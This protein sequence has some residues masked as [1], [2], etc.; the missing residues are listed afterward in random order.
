[1][2]GVNRTRK[3]RPNRGGAACAALRA[4]VFGWSAL[5]FV[6]GLGS[7]SPAIAAARA[8]VD[9][10]TKPLRHYGSLFGV[11]LDTAGIP[12]IAAR[13]NIIHVESSVSL[14]IQTEGGRFA[15][16]HLPAGIYQVLGR[17]VGYTP[18]LVDSILVA[19]EERKHV[20]VVLLR[21]PVIL[22]GVKVVER[23]VPTLSELPEGF[24]SAEDSRNILGAAELRA[25]RQSATLFDAMRDLRPLLLGGERASAYRHRPELYIDGKYVPCLAATRMARTGDDCME[26]LLGELLVE[27]VEDVQYLDASKAYIVK[28]AGDRHGI[29]PVLLVRRRLP[30][31]R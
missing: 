14:T 25:Y 6:I 28:G 7:L 2:R 21:A 26:G 3:H 4:R 23:T 27:Q 12:L 18:T 15:V 16:D 30:R 22:S 29:G 19:P 9:T 10:S 24:R 31:S 13:V 11:V 8:Q 1:M 17:A 20:D 5:A